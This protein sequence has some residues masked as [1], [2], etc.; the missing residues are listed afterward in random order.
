MSRRSRLR[1]SR[2]SL[3]R[4]RPKL[5]EALDSPLPFSGLAMKVFA[6]PFKGVAPNASVL[7]GVELRG[8]DLRLDPTDKVAV[9]YAVVGHDGKIRAGSTD[10]LAMTLK[11]ETKTRVAASGLRLL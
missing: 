4:P 9:T 7:L 3:Q 8:R 11:P 10:S 1:P 6:T 5:R 2:K